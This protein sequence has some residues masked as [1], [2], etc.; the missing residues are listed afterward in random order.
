MLQE[1]SRLYDMPSETD[2]ASAV[3]AQNGS[4]RKVRVLVVGVGNILLKDEG[5]GV[6]VAKK[7]LETALPGDVE[8][9]D[10]GTCGLDILLLY[11]EVEKL[12]VVDATRA[13]HKAG[14][15]YK[16]VLSAGEIQRPA[17]LLGG[18]A[19]SRISLH[20]VGLTEALA[21]ANKLNRAPKKIVIIGVEP[22]ECNWGLELTGPVARSVPEVV[23]KVLE[24]I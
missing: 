2:A 5:V 22:G 14:T 19:D 15:I 4:A 23:N 8:V 13:G 1:S 12:I 9:I 17:Q 7:L 24:E 10:C 6:H 20:Q 3:G 16:A 21:A 18:G 11:K